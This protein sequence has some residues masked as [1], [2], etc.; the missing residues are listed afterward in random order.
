MVIRGLWIGA[1]F[2]AIAAFLGPALVVGPASAIETS[3]PMIVR[4][5]ASS[6]DELTAALDSLGVN[7]DHTYTHTIHGAAAELT[8]QEINTL[9]HEVPGAVISADAL[10][11]ISS[12]Q[13]SPTWGLDTL[14]QTS[15]TLDH[16]YTYPTSAGSGVDV[17]VIDTGL[18]ASTYAAGGELSGRV[19]AGKNFARSSSG[20]GVDP[21][22][23]R[24]CLVNQ[25]GHQDGGHG[26]HV[27]GT[28]ASTTY[29]VAKRATIIPLRVFP[30]ATLDSQN[31]LG[32][33]AQTGDVIAAIDWAVA[34]H[35]K[36]GRPGVINL[37]LGGACSRGV[38]SSDELVLAASA[39]TNTST[40]NGNSLP[41]LTVVVA[42][43]NGDT[44]QHGI[45]ACTVAPAASP[46]VI[47]V[48]AVDQ[49]RAITAWSNYGSCVSVF[50]P[51]LNITSLNAWQAPASLDTSPTANMSGT[52][53]ASPHVAG[54]AA[55]YLALHPRATPAQVKAAIISGALD[56]AVSGLGGAKATSPNRMLNVGWLDA[57]PPHIP[58]VT[59]TSV[60]GVR[61]DRVNL[62]WQPSGQSSDLTIDDYSV[63]YKKTNTSQWSIFN[64]GVNTATLATVTGLSAGSAY[65]FQ[66]IPLA[67]NSIDPTQSA[68]VVSV[69]TLTGRTSKV[70]SL[71][72]ST[73]TYSS[74][75]LRWGRPLSY[76]GGTITD[77]VIKYRRL[78]TTTWNTFSDGISTKTIA[79]VSGLRARTTYTFA[80]YPKTAQGL[81]IAA[82]YNATTK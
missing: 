45:D 7:P 26:T 53:M 13:T 69:S 8:P 75:T 25:G 39:A 76:N 17:Y 82:F 78:G 71:T 72:L 61:V 38:C 3:E 24:E 5:P 2:V 35:Q 41:G 79:R 50:A 49:S 19:T 59:N 46:I 14:D 18:R 43:G 21:S 58:A 10:V 37:S 16:S 55:L 28:I 66:V 31:Q 48:G 62:A 34:H 80:V 20:A 73:R 52:S 33:D 63:E 40:V 74:V 30:C 36:T 77:Y 32:A 29:G 12:L 47:T 27:A 56:G 64:D 11:H 65:D 22:D 60:S 6:N 15:P 1:T 67:N 9:R 57:A 42:A 81:G 4:V 68:Q 44:S 23:T 54:V 51:G 70:V